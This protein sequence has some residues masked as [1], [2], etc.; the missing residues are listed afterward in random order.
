MGRLG[1]MV[2]GLALLAG[3][4]TPQER[5][6]ASA[7]RD[8]RILD[9]LITETQGNID[10]GFAYVEVQRSRTVWVVCVPAQAA[11]ATSPAQSA[12]M[13]MDDQYYTETRPQAINLADERVKL[14]EMRKKR[15]ELERAAVRDVASCKAQHP[16]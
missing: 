14:A 16:K 15:A 7:T 13:C 3:C 5:C 11:T 12:Q 2:L 10:R 8:A 1:L 6:I 4:G 9:R